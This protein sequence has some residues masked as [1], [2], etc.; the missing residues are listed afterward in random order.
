MV[1]V[2]E[3]NSM[4]HALRSLLFLLYR[5]KRAVFYTLAF[6]A[7]YAVGLSGVSLPWESALSF[8]NDVWKVIYYGFV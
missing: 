5:V 2:K 3:V 6:L 8:F 4:I 7:G 1:F